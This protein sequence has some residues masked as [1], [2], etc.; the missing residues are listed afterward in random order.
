MKSCVLYSV[1]GILLKLSAVYC[2]CHGSG[3][4][5][6]EQNGCSVIQLRVQVSLQ[7]SFPFQQGN[8]CK[9]NCK[10]KKKE[11]SLMALYFIFFPTTVL[12]FCSWVGYHIYPL[13]GPPNFRHLANCL[14]RVRRHIGQVCHAVLLFSIYQRRELVRWILPFLLW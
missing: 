6:I 7:Y 5:G 13:L 11:L 1:H 3:F 4:H 14:A 9:Q 10:L 8:L 12:S 2:C